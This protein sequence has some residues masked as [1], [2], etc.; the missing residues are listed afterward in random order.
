MAARDCLGA[1]ALQWDLQV[2]A[3]LHKRIPQSTTTKTRSSS[4]DKRKWLL[5]GSAQAARPASFGRA[6]QVALRRDGRGGSCSRAERF[7]RQ[8][9]GLDTPAAC[10]PQ[11]CFGRPVRAG[12]ETPNN[13][14]PSASGRL[15]RRGTT[16]TS[17][18]ATARALF[19]WLNKNGYDGIEAT[20]RYFAAKFFPGKPTDEVAIAARPLLRRRACAFS[21]PTFGGALTAAGRTGPS[22]T[23]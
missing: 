8:P 23:K 9:R 19:K 5:R 3:Q 12:P 18:T 16:A 4:G 22:S 13:V 17:R 7:L 10:R 2:R 1:W 6:G 20:A 15:I 14:L 21:A 11:Y